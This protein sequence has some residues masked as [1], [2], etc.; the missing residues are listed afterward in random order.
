M[1]LNCSAT[2]TNDCFGL[3]DN[4]HVDNQYFVSVLWIYTAVIGVES[5]L[6]VYL[7]CVKGFRTRINTVLILISALM[8]AISTIHYTA[9]VVNVVAFKKDMESSANDDWELFYGAPVA[10]TSQYYEPRNGIAQATLQQ[11]ICSD[12]VVLWRAWILWGKSRRVFMLSVVFVASTTVVSVGTGISWFI[13]M[14]NM[15][16][17]GRVILWSFSLATNILGTGLIAYK[18]WQHRR[19]MKMYIAGASRMTIVETT[20]AL[21]VESGVVYCCVWA[22]PLTSLPSAYPFLH[23]NDTRTPWLN[24][25]FP[26]ILVQISLRV[27]VI[28]IDQGMYPT[29][30]TVLV[31]LQKTAFD[32][33]SSVRETPTQAMEFATGPN[34]NLV[35]TFSSQS[36]VSRRQTMTVASR[37]TIRTRRTTLSSS[38]IRIGIAPA[39]GMQRDDG[40]SCLNF[41]I[42]SEDVESQYME[43]SGGTDEHQ[44]GLTV[45]MGDR[46]VQK[47]TASKQS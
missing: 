6:Y 11:F 30:I 2:F 22:D 32:I 39:T 7:L 9:T 28:W 16:I 41:M 25:V 34:P 17:T 38:T 5:A 37:D 45:S 24:Q 27:S 26:C 23:L 33:T 8:F 20:L 18:A 29:A 42:P 1:S 43:M 36:E 21:L 13:H 44:S 15:W 19:S 47:I 40:E 10:S 12:A 14:A 35:A 46:T 4:I 31:A 3:L